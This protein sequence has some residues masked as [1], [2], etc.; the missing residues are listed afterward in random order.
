MSI[1]KS[2]L[3]KEDPSSDTQS[4]PAATGRASAQPATSVAPFASAPATPLP[5]IESSLP[6]TH[7]LF[8]RALGA[9]PMLYNWHTNFSALEA[10]IPDVKTRATAALA[11]ARGVTKLN[12]IE[13]ERKAYQSLEILIMDAEGLL[14]KEI[15]ASNA[16]AAELVNESNSGLAFTQKRIEELKAELEAAT[17]EEIRLK[18]SLQAAEQSLAN[19]Q[20]GNL[21]RKQERLKAHAELLQRMDSLRNL[22][23]SLT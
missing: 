13:G 11:T 10:A 3:F 16:A 8:D 21:A 9:A 18:Q 6:S 20:A 7:E 14:E 17:V 5:E 22:F 19:V 4:A 12:L 2:W 1:L 15:A 23:Q